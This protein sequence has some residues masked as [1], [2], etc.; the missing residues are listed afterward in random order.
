MKYLILYLALLIPILVMLL[1]SFVIL[2]GGE[3]VLEVLSVFAAYSTEQ[4]V[5]QTGQAVL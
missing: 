3:A 4:I 1:I 5:V 2:F